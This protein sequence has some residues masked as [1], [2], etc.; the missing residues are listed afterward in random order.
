MNRP[1]PH[2]LTLARIDTGPRRSGDHNPHRGARTLTDRAVS[3]RWVWL[4]LLPLLVAAATPAIGGTLLWQQTPDGQSG[5]GPSIR[6]TLVD[7]EIADDFHVTGTI[8][9]VVATGYRGF[10]APPSPAVQAVEVRFYAVDGDRPGAVIAEY[11]LAGNN[12]ELSYDPVGVNTFDIT[13]S[14]PFEATGHH[15]IGV[16]VVMEA[17]WAK[18]SSGNG[19]ARLLPFWIKDDLAGGQWEPYSDALGTH[20][21]D[22]AFELYGTLGG[23]PQISG[24][25]TPT[26]TRSGRVRIFGVNFGGTAAGGQVLIDGHP[27]IVAEWTDQAIHAYVPETATPGTVDVVVATTFGGASSPF[28]LEVTTRVAEGQVNWRFTC[29]G[30]GVRHR[31]GIG[32]DGTIY[33]QDTD[34]LLYALSADGALLWIT[35]TGGQG[36]EGPV[37]V[38]ADGTIYVAANPLGPTVD[39]VAVRPDGSIL[40]RFTDTDTQGLLAGPGIGPDGRIYAVIEQPGLGAVA[41]DPADGSL[42]WSNP[43]SPPVN[44]HGQLGTEIAFGADRF[45]VSF[46]ERAQSPISL[47]YGFSLDGAQV[48]AVGRPNDNAE[49]E[50]G[51]NGDFYLPVWGSSSGISLG[52]YDADGNLQWTA[53]GSLTNVLTNPSVGPDG[54]VYVS[55]NLQELWAIN[56]DGSTRWSVTDADVLN[57]PEVSPDGGTLLVGGAVWGSHGFIRAFDSADGSRLWEEIIPP[58]LGYGVVPSARPL[59]SGDGSFAVVPAEP[60]VNLN[61]NLHCYIYSLSTSSTDP[62]LIFADDFE[63]GGA[64]R[65]SAQQ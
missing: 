61:D 27:A 65:W 59:F 51:P 54:T 35:D 63:N 23:E 58:E 14:P 24:L 15:Y 31:V 55:R 5:Y 19:T 42:E 25:S 10:G 48:F 26:A 9:R 30:R 8:D 7:K 11:V 13:L 57:S 1:T 29:D 39:I 22:V 33:A 4:L 17:Y 46:D 56:P 21:D 37:V 3:M 62:S 6:S 28:P 20:L 50:V 49:A 32:P 64:G 41:L 45:Y 2:P 40:W 36:G 43:G 44:E 12:P 47:I 53:V 52:A 18:P 38:G 34:G 60:G 16:Q